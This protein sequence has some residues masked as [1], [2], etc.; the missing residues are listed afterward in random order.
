M[1]G[2]SCIPCLRAYNH[3]KLDN[4]SIECVFLGYA[5]NHKSYMCLDS[6]TD[7]VYIS[8]HVVFNESS[9]PFHKLTNQCIAPC[10]ITLW[11]HALEFSSIFVPC[12]I[13]TKCPRFVNL[14][15]LKNL[16][17]KKR[18]VSVSLAY[19]MVTKYGVAPPFSP[20]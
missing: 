13:E 19:P 7:C 20:N 4:R 15:N 8:H 1:F 9:F 18:E 2:C 3:H 5:S 12:N 14:F 11:L 17:I 6:H 10:D 16:S